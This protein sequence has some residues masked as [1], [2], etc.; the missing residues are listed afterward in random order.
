MSKNLPA[1]VAPSP[2][3]QWYGRATRRVR[4]LAVFGPKG[5]GKTCFFASLYGHSVDLWA[6]LTFDHDP[7]TDY[8]EKMW[9]A[10]TQDATGFPSPTGAEIPRQLLFDLAEQKKGRQWKAEILDHAGELIHRIPGGGDKDK[11]LTEQL[12]EIV[13]SWLRECEAILIFLDTTQ[14][15]SKESLERRNEVA[16][17]LQLCRDASES[18]QVTRPLGIVLTKW[19]SLPTRWT[20]PIQAESNGQQNTE[21]D[22]RIKLAREE[23]VAKEYLSKTPSLRQIHQT[24][25][26][27]GSAVSVFPV[28]A[29]GFNRQ[30]KCNPSDPYN[31]LTPLLWALRQT[32]ESRG[33][34]AETKVEGNSQSLSQKIQTYQ[35]LIDADDITCGPVFDRIHPRLAEL[36]KRHGARRVAVLGSAIGVSLFLLMSFFGIVYFSWG[37]H[38]DRRYQAWVSFCDKEGQGDV[39]AG[40]RLAMAEDIISW[41]GMFLNHEQ[42]SRIEDCRMRDPVTERDFNERTE[43]EGIQEDVKR[44]VKLDPPQQIDLREGLKKRLESF[45]KKHTEFKVGKHWERELDDVDRT[46]VKQYAQRN[47]FETVVAKEKALAPTD[48]TQTAKLIHLWEVYLATDPLPYFQKQAQRKIGTWEDR[49][50]DQMLESLRNE[51]RVARQDLIQFANFVQKL[52]DFLTRD[53]K[54][55]SRKDVEASVNEMIDDELAK[56]DESAYNQATDAIGAART[57]LGTPAQVLGKLQVAKKKVQEY[58]APAKLGRHDRPRTM[59]PEAER[60]ERWFTESGATVF[61]RIARL[62][63]RSLIYPLPA[64]QR[65]K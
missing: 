13:R 26:A 36:K 44:L 46:L 7:T 18:G 34:A 32:D 64:F 25:E 54:N 53:R 21:E 6:S 5:S 27:F 28:S 40:K 63:D 39:N 24:V 14:A 45:G 15:D 55:K 29:I 42:K 38:A 61:D 37:A 22:L 50:D 49:W 19:D 1:E 43:W 60:C 3:D 30:P 65:G 57:M 10:Y 4:R 52:D 17:L 47:E 35:E 62:G 8:L 9:N 23:Q 48:Q 51:A 16:I 58:L 41:H 2:V 56:A 20:T 33:Q 11:Q 12:R 31:I 59:A